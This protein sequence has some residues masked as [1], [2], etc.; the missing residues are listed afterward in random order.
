MGAEIFQFG[1]NNWAKEYWRTHY[2]GWI[3]RSLY[4]FGDDDTLVNAFQHASVPP[5]NLYEP[6]A[7]TALAK[8]SHFSGG[9]RLYSAVI[10]MRFNA[11]LV[12][13]DAAALQAHIAGRAASA[14]CPV[15]WTRSYARE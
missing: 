7:Y 6:A 14:Q 4:S 15:R 1:A 3:R 12:L 9:Y 10:N 13:V 11:P 8:T 5:N 2:N